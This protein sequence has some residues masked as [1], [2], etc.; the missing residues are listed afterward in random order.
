VSARLASTRLDLLR[1]RHRLGLVEKGRDLLRRKRE[2]L[3]R[4]LLQQ[5]RPAADARASIGAQASEAYEALLGAREAQGDPGVEAL[6]WPRRPLEVEL[7]ARQV[8]GVAAPL[9]VRLPAV[10]RTLAA[11]G[12]STGAGPSAIGAADAF[13]GLVDLLLGAASRELLI[14]RL[15]GALAAASRQV[16]TLEQRVAPVLAAEIGRV[17]RVLDERE[18]EERVRTRHLLRRRPGATG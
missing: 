2:A 12:T 13:E 7:E 9:L 1:G 4:E 8:W 3:V 11:R 6:G 14:E 18:R 5:A 15:G 16:R 10:R 17:R